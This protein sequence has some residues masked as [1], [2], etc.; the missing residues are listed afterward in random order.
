MPVSTN[1]LLQF[2]QALGVDGPGVAN[3]LLGLDNPA[4][5]AGTINGTGVSLT[6]DYVNGT[7]HQMVV[8]FTNVV[9]A[10]TDLTTNGAIGSLKFYDMPVGLINIIGCRTNLTAVAAAGISASAT[11][12]HAVGTAAAATN[13][14]LDSTKANIIAS[15]NT[16]L[17]SSAGAVKGVSTDAVQ[18][19]GTASAAD[20]YLN[21]GIADAG[22][23]TNS[24]LT[25]N[26]TITMTWQ[27]LS[28]S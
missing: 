5:T 2:G 21:F 3:R 22:T 16:S 20:I 12:K 9:I 23:T 7:E 25:L 10:T 14:T 13:D 6:A 18:I 4:V 28:V 11:L 27:N 19:D 8:T 26:G 17:S 24:T 1:D 15:T